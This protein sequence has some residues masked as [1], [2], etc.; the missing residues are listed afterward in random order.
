MTPEEFLPEAPL[1]LLRHHHKL[2]D[3][4]DRWLKADPVREIEYFAM[5]RDIEARLTRIVGGTPPAL[6][7][8][9]MVAATLERDG[10]FL[11]VVANELSSENCREPEVWKRVLAA[12]A[13]TVLAL[14]VKS[15]GGT[16]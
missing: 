6:T 2:D 13:G 16:P 9:K 3:V 11:Y 15:K 1:A 4:L 8:R 14:Y 5:I 12:C 7:L 10:T